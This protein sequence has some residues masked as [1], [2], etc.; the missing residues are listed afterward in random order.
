ML[1]SNFVCFVHL[2]SFGFEL[3]YAIFSYFVDATLWNNHC[4]MNYYATVD[5]P[6]PSPECRRN[7]HSWIRL[8]LYYSCETL[9]EILRENLLSIRA[10]DSLFRADNL[11]VWGQFTC[12]M[13]VSGWYWFKLFITNHKPVSHMW[14]FDDIWLKCKDCSWHLL[15]IYKILSIWTFFIF[16]LNGCIFKYTDEPIKHHIRSY[17]QT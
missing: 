8:W 10:L 9:R 4:I 15:L 12:V 1:S 3:Q 7:Q 2:C 14:D 11:N 17:N 16:N 13:H 5:N 6:N